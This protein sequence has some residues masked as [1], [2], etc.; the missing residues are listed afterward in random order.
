M[1]PA[2]P[3]LRDI[4]LPPAPWW[5]LAPGWWVL[6][7]VAVALAIVLLLWWRRR[8]SARLVDA[9][10]QEVTLLEARFARDSDGA[11]LAAAASRLL[12][13][14]AL[15]VEPEAAGATG[16]AWQEFVRRRAGDPAVAHT[17]A[18]LADAAFVRQPELDAPALLQA[19]RCW[20]RRALRQR[21]PDGVV[22]TG[23]AAA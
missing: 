20:C 10:L 1:N 23:R 15:R 22:A 8:R 16:V 7:G 18:V 5:P 2:G 21:A 17:L 3:I 14:V 11:A 9:V 12:R 19:L 4:H 13:R 6:A